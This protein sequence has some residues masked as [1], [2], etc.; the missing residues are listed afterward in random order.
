MPPSEDFVSS[1]AFH[2]PKAS[3]FSCRNTPS[4]YASRGWATFNGT[5]VRLRTTSLC[6]SRLTDTVVP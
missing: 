2:D 3:R 4:D 1:P 5:L 6:N